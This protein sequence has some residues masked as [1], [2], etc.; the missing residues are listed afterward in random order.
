MAYHC[1][2]SSPLFLSNQ[3]KEVWRQWIVLP[4]TLLACDPWSGTTIDKDQGFG[5]LKNVSDRIAPEIV[6][7]VGFENCLQTLPM[8]CIERLGKVE[9]DS[10]RRNLSVV[11]ALH[12]L[13]HKDEGLRD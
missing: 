5:R 2:S 1:L 13:C 8:D 10:K 4:E 12:Q 11:A 3:Q 9:F 6:E 7:A